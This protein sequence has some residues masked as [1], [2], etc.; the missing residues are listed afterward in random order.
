MD[1]P[2]SKSIEGNSIFS[3]NLIAEAAENNHELFVKNTV[4]DTQITFRNISPNAEVPF[5][6]HL[7]AT[8]FILVA[9]GELEITVGRTNKTL[10]TLGSAIVAPGLP[11]R[12]FNNSPELAKVI[13][14][15]SE[16]QHG[17]EDFGYVDPKFVKFEE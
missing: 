1:L 5:E 6:A 12:I 8:Q 4:G 15:Y 11:H 7:R 16:I 3:E 9:L 2:T 10:K 13:I 17:V 14:I